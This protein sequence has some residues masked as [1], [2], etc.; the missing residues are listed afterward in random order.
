MDDKRA[1][2]GT[3]EFYELGFDPVVEISAEHGQGTGDLLDAIIERLGT[4]PSK[5]AV[6]PAPEVSVAIIGRPNGGKSSLV[7]RLLGFPRALVDASAGTTRDAL[8]TLLEILVRRLN[9]ADVR[10][11]HCVLPKPSEFSILEKSKKLHLQL[12]R[13]LAHFVEK[14]RP[15]SGQIEAAQLFI[16]PSAMQIDNH[17][18]RIN[19]ESFV[20][21]DQC[22]GFFA[23]TDMCISF[24]HPDINQ[25][26]V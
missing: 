5:E 1:R 3:I 6:E 14:Q 12:F 24:L 17:V 16:R 10:V 15:R 25:S 4:A 18:L 2:A 26:R 8:D 23:Q 13:H 19:L 20:E 7:N 11:T 9:H 21:C 22:L